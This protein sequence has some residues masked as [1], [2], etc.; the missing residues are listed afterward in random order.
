MTLEDE[1]YYTNNE[2]WLYMTP[3]HQRWFKMTKLRDKN[4]IYDNVLSLNRYADMNDII[5]E[6]EKTLG[7]RIPHTILTIHEL[8][9][10]LD[11]HEEH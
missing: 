11:T 10:W 1:H 6:V 9:K 8:Y 5:T 4:W 3:E 2:W 7:M